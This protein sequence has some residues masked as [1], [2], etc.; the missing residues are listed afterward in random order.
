[1]PIPFKKYGYK[2]NPITDEIETP[3]VFLVNKQL[4]KIG[5]LYPIENLGIT[6]NEVNQPDEISFSYYKEVNNTPCPYFEDL[7]DFSVIQVGNFGF[8]ECQVSKTEN[9]SI[10][11][12]VVGRSLGQAELSQ[13]LATLEV[14]TDDDMTRSGYDRNY[15]TI[16]YR[17]TDITDSAELKKKKENSS[18][19]NRILSY[20]PHYKIGYVSPTLKNVQRTFSWDDKD[21]VS[22]LNDVATEVNCIFDIQVTINEEGEAERIINAYDMQYCEHCWNALDEKEQKTNNTHTFRNI[23]NGV[24]Q[25][26]GS[27]KNIKDIGQDTN[28]FISTENLSDEIFI[29]SDKDSVKNCFKVVGGDDLMTA[30]VQGLQMSAN[31]RI[32]MFSD[33]YKKKM[34][35]SLVEKLEEYQ[36][37]YAT[38]QPE[39]EKLLE[40]QY[41]IYDIIQ[42]LKSGKMP[43]LEE[44]ITTTLEALLY[45]LKQIKVYYDNHFY[46]SR[47]SYYDY[48]SA[49]S[50]INNLFTTFMP[51]GFS[52]SIDTDELTYSTDKNYQSQR[53]YQWFGSIKVYNTGNRDDFYT[54]MLVKNEI[55]SITHGKGNTPI[56][57]V[58]IDG[59]VSNFSITF[60]FADKEQEAYLSYL[61]Q[62]ASYLLSENELKY[63][64]EKAREWNEYS[65]NRLKSF[66]DGFQTCIDVLSEMPNEI[67]TEGADEIVQ[68][69][70]STYGRIQED[71]HSQ[72]SL[73]LDQIFAL[74]V[75]LGEYSSEFT[76]QNGDVTYELQNF[77]Y[78]YE[79]LAHMID[80]LYKGGYEKN[81]DGTIQENSFIPNEF[82]GT[83]PCKCKK[84]GSINVSATIEGNRCNNCSGTSVYSYYDIM[85]D[86][87]TWYETSGRSEIAYQRKQLRNQFDIKKYFHDNLYNELLSFIR[88]DVYQNENYT[89]DGLTNAQLITQ[90]KELNAKA[91]QELSKAC[92]AQ[93]TITAPISAIVA[94]TE[95]EYQGVT[96]NDDYSGFVINNYVRV[97]IDDEVYKMRIASIDFSF[98]I[99]DKIDV[100]FSNVTNCKTNTTM[101][102]KEILDSA[103]NMAT[104]YSYVATQAEKGEVANLQFDKLKN[105][106]LDAG[107]MAVK[108]GRDQDVVI[109][110]HGILVRKKIQE[111]GD[112]SPYQMKIINR[113]LVL[114]TNDWK[115]ASMAIG[116]GTHTIDGKK[117][118][119][120]GI[121]ADVLVGNLTCTKELQVTNDKGTVLIDENG[122]KVED[123]YLNIANDKYSVEIDPNNEGKNTRD[124]YLF[125][126]RDI[127]EA[128]NQQVIMGVNTNGKGYF[129]GDV[130]TSNI[131][132][133]GGNIGKFKIVTGSIVGYTDAEML[134]YD[135]DAT[136]AR[137]DGLKVSISNGRIKCNGWN[138]YNDQLKD[139]NTKTSII[140]RDG[141]FVKNEF[142]N[143]K[144]LLSI[145]NT[146]NNIEINCNEMEINGTLKGSAFQWK[147]KEVRGT[148]SISTADIFDRAKEIVVQVTENSTG[149]YYTY[150]WNIIPHSI[151]LG[152][153]NILIDGYQWGSVY[154]MC[155]V[156]LSRSIV[157]LYNCIIGGNEYA[158]NATLSIHYR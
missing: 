124:D 72:M 103:S 28:I 59:V 120:Y 1:M 95:F 150:T 30:T 47:W 2:I 25:N 36:S 37:N 91:Q 136:S 61:K 58:D 60:S 87:V 128:D 66:Y 158:E 83:K 117:K 5:E 79:V 81:P 80:P 125:A 121:W 38:K 131:I 132:A 147:T 101:N 133:D 6:L 93:Y 12:K 48:T 32:M 29:E 56:S 65:Y 152:D 76:N 57:Y 151:G 148:N 122:I 77:T 70:I 134:L 14:N 64:N 10:F 141:I 142:G 31:N 20:A 9:I 100:T 135:G 129:K 140:S 41:D 63:D 27:S 110:N 96:V 74:N 18:L 115:D 42:Y 143:G 98:P 94:Q 89:S 4:K 43:L 118:L 7:C 11:K 44:E 82:I 155:R 21:I 49:K 26:C 88:E 85:N 116:L 119:V 153:G 17:D 108:G 19:L 113:N 62:H 53:I 138:S 156:R 34:S 90:A 39:Y 99:T 50:S 146:N 33:E 114:T 109:D 16:F 8:F 97:R 149:N 46:I 24:C 105:E 54:L 107:L 23:V 127:N 102:L 145:S 71:I 139:D 75:C 126:I 137:T 86:I 68:E 157:Q 51:K 104:S 69:M 106:G 13:I 130:V 52:F 73:L 45:T 15:P 154:G 22:V 123:G 67:P 84:C 35:R 92:E 144:Q 78:V 55:P 112:Y 111:T 40:T 3:Q